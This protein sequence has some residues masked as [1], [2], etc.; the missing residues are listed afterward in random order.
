MFLRIITP[1][2]IIRIVPPGE[3]A[4]RAVGQSLAVRYRSGPGAA[5]RIRRAGPASLEVAGAIADS[6]A[7]ARG[8]R[9]WLLREARRLLAPWLAAESLRLGLGYAKTSVR[10]QRSRWG[11]CSSAKTISLNAKLLFLPR[12]LAQYVL[13]HELAHIAHLDHSPAFWA[14][15][16]RLRPGARTLDKALRRAGA[17]VPGWV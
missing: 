5:V 7:V 10:L 8:L 3:V 11:S 13:D 6:L 15:L 16:E 14:L 4:L 9:A 1:A 12:D 17:F 2:Q